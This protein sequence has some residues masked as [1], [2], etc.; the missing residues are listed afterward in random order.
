MLY[1]LMTIVTLT[2]IVFL[3]KGTNLSWHFLIN[4]Y[5][6]GVMFVDIAEI[7]FNQFMGL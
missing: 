5:A 7:T 3:K 6:I 2:W 1:F 4:T